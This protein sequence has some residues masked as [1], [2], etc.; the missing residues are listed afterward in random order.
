MTQTAPDIQTKKRIG[1]IPYHQR[2][3]HGGMGAS[4]ESGAPPAAA[5]VN[6]RAWSQPGT[7]HAVTQPGHPR[8]YREAG[9]P[10]DAPR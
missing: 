6:G 4:V 10:K 9:F 3:T 7:A 5:I 8:L 2:S 1:P